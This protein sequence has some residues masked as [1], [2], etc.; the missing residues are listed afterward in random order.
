MGNR[1]SSDG[2]TRVGKDVIQQ[3]ESTSTA[4]YD[5]LNVKNSGRLIVAYRKALATKDF[6]EVNE[7]I[8]SLKEYMYDDGN[9]RN[10][11]IARLV[12]KR[13]LS[14]EADVDK[15]SRP[16]LI[17]LPRRKDTKRVHSNASL[18][19]NRLALINMAYGPDAL[20]QEPAQYRHLCWKVGELGAVGEN[21]LHT[22]FLNATRTHFDLGMLLIK[23]YPKIINDIYTS[24]EY[25]GENCLHMAIVN[26]DLAL[27]HF[28]CKNGIDIH[29][30]ACGA[31]FCPDDQKSSR[32]DC[33]T[34]ESVVLCTE[35][36]YQS[37]SNTYWGEYP[38]SFAAC[39]GQEDTVKYL[40][41]RRACPN[42]QDSNG[43]T[44]LHMMVIH[45]Q[46]DMYDLLVDYGCWCSCSLC[47]NGVQLH[48]RNRQGFTPLTLAAKLAR[49]EMFHHILTK[50]REVF[51]EYGNVTAAAFP[52]WELDT[53]GD[54]GQV[55]ERSAINIIIHEDSH[56]HLELLDGIVLNILTEKW[57]HGCRFRFFLLL[58]I[59]MMYL[60]I[61]SVALGIRPSVDP[62]CAGK[63]V[64]VTTNITNST[65][66]W[67]YS[68]VSL[69]PVK[70]DPCFLRNVI[71]QSKLHVFRAVLEVLATI[72]AI[73]YLVLIAVEMC[74]Q[75][76]RTVFWGLVYNPIRG[77]FAVS[78]ALIPC[79]LA[80]RFAC[81]Q[82]VEDPLTVVALVLAWPYSL[83]FCK[84]FQ[85]TGPY[86]VM[87]Y[88]M[89][90]RDFIIFFIIY[91]IFVIGFSQA[92]FLAVSGYLDDSVDEHMFARWFSSGLVLIIMSLGEF[93]DPLVQLV[94]SDSPYKIIGLF[95]FFIFMVLGALLIVNMLIAM[96]GNT[97]QSVSETKKEWTRQ[98]AQIVL[99]IERMLTPGKRLRLLHK[100]SEPVGGQ[101][102]LI[103]RLRQ[104]N[105]REQS[106]VS[107]DPKQ[108][109]ASNPSNGAAT[110]HKDAEYL[111]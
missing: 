38:L 6:T 11:P 91:G 27:V 92:M 111:K 58:C 62:S 53:I 52:L 73:S 9:G 7:L 49:N 105:N 18:Q 66:N 71:Y 101:R 70:C 67:S 28:L 68:K 106:K 34:Q 107:H 15:N 69:E 95:V 50:S 84:G 93:G 40:L 61:F 96:M 90:K 79:C 88:Q 63:F 81:L 103:M 75:G 20:E 77:L 74:H 14:R 8:A 26:G 94:E 44:V 48:I 100:Y 39:L 85:L 25:Y 22:C 72:W 98:W 76:V 59:Y 99:D 30:R 60:L 64:N 29:Q 24:D 108:H 42:K 5:L 3:T 31:F 102:A 21:I 51:W 32:E 1:G 2:T 46:K 109:K 35:T 87:I 110:F 47:S 43:N 82:K 55:I 10:V 78:C 4:W 65:G 16:S 23:A 45:D 57:K 33:E 104:H 19:G 17:C 54:Q 97:Y 80:T 12:H 83:M 86:V 89:L 13:G 37:L 56:E 36:N 41:H